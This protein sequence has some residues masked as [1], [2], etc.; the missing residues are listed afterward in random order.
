[1]EDDD[2]RL[3]TLDL[4]RQRAQPVAHREQRREHRPCW[5]VVLRLSEARCKA[6][7]RLENRSDTSLE[8]LAELTQHGLHRA[9]VAVVRANVQIRDARFRAKRVDRVRRAHTRRRVTTSSNA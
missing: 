8:L 2:V 3:L 1:P 6:I 9:I 4:L 7:E 5:R